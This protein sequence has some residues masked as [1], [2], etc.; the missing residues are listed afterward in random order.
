MPARKGASRRADVPFGTLERLNCGELETATLAE[1]LAVDFAVL[2]RHAAPEV[3]AGEVAARL[4]PTDGV[5]KRMAAA[6]RLLLE[7]FG[8]GGLRRFSSHPSD[9]VRGWSA[10][11]LAQAPGL[12]L[13][14][15]LRM[16]RPLADDHH[17]GVREWAWLA[18][19]PHVA[20]DVRGAVGALEGWLG[21]TSP[22]LRRFA[23]EITRPRGVWSTHIEELKREP[24]IGLPL[25]EPAKADP[26][27]YVQDSVAN[28]LNDASKSRPDWVLEL[29]ERWLSES[30]AP[31]TARIRSR[32][33]RSLK[34]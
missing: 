31:E 14:E 6:G 18:L 29:C 34:G 12:G 5:T 2:M 25:L 11:S 27:R 8:L 21:E 24:G 17:F 4:K 9:T 13:E 28:W 1:G 7:H 15:R 20:A 16:V 33:L 30:D 22:N 10:Y 3:P 26:T 32:A 19:R 23:V